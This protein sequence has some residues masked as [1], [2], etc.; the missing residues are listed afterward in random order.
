MEAVA[1]RFQLDP[2]LLKVVDLAVVD[3]DEPAIFS[4][5]GLV[6]GRTEVDDRQTAVTQAHGPV[7]VDAVAIRPAMGDGVGHPLEDN[8]G[9]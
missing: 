5:H 3:H 7:G 1:Q 9:D 2:Q 6:P 8:R 4:G